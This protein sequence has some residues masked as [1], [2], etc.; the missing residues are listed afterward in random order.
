MAA[1]P[2]R[3]DKVKVGPWTYDIEWTNDKKWV[4]DGHNRDWG[5][6]SA[7]VENKIFMRIGQ[8]AEGTLKET[9]LH[10]ILHCVFVVTGL[11]RYPEPKSKYEDADEYLI[12]V[13]TPTL[14]HVMQDNPDVFEYLTSP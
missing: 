11:N 7:H 3:P 8:A 13:M 4:K 2:A 9:L 10:E 6:E 14:L 5:G 12:H 1:A